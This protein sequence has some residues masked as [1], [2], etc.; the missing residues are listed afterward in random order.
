MNRGMYE[1]MALKPF[2]YAMLGTAAVMWWMI[3]L[4][5]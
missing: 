4:Y 3:V 5:I 2:L 1:K